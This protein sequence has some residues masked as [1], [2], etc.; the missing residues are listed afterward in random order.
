MP[1]T[2]GTAA[3]TTINYVIPTKRSGKFVRRPVRHPRSRSL[4]PT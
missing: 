2:A 3:E 4:T 1:T